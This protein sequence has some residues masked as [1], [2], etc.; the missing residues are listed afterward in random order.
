MSPSRSFRD[1]D[2]SY[3]ASRVARRYPLDVAIN[4]CMTSPTHSPPSYHPPITSH[5]PPIHH[6]PCTTHCPLP[7]YPVLMASSRSIDIFAASRRGHQLLYDQYQLLFPLQEGSENVAIH[8][9]M[10]SISNGFFHSRFSMYMWYPD[11]IG[12][13]SWDWVVSAA[14]R[15]A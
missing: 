8:T 13:D 2:A 5:P 9:C 7:T 14:W 10:A 3:Y 4:L 15:R 11:H 6:P 1:V 12:R